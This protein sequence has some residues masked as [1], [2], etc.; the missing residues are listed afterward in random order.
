MDPFDFQTEKEPRYDE[1]QE[2][3][4]Y[5]EFHDNQEKRN[6]KFGTAAL[7]LGIIGLV[8]PYFIYTSLICGTLAIIFGLLSKGGERTVDKRGKTG[9]ILGIIS[10]V[11][12]IVILIGVFRYV[13]S[14]FGGMDGLMQYYNDYYDYPSYSDTL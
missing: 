5:N 11:I 14:S 8:T 2:Y 9:I 6:L 1:Y 4:E 10:L 12:T 7:V 3:Q 13:F